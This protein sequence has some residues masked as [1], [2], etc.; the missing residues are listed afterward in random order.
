MDFIINTYEAVGSV[1]F[2]MTQAE[3]HEIL[4]VP[5]KE[6]RRSLEISDHFNGSN[7]QVFYSNATLPVCVAVQFIYSPNYSSEL[8]IPIFREKNL[9]DGTSLKKLKSWFES[10]DDSI[11]V[12]TDGITAYGLGIGLGSEDSRLFKNKPP[13][14]VIA[15]VQGYYDVISRWSQ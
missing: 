8:P 15:F 2:G 11:E 9:L 1:R 7:M 5:S 6:I 3:V 10:M 14:T 4:G 13:Q 12:N